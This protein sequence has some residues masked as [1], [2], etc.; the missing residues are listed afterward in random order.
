M[1]WEVV[2][3][4]VTRVKLTVAKDRVTVKFPPTVPSDEQE[5]FLAMFRRMIERFSPVEHTIR[6][7]F[8]PKRGGDELLVHR[9][10]GEEGS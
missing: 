1:R 6:Y 9:L 10:L 2:T 4:D 7:S 5:K 8:D 3:K